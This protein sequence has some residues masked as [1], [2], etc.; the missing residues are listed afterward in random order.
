MGS[1]TKAS[2]PIGGTHKCL[3]SEQAAELERRARELCGNPCMPRLRNGRRIGLVLDYAEF[4]Q[5]RGRGLVDRGIVTDLNSGNRYNIRGAS[6][7]LPECECDKIAIKVDYA[8]AI[9]PRRFPCSL[10]VRTRE[11]LLSIS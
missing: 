6:C 9:R 8:P 4:M 1:K 3:T 7:G 5:I 10:T 11:I 2:R